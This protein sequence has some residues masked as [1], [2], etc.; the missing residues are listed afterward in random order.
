MDE[1]KE[2]FTSEQEIE[3]TVMT[4]ADTTNTMD[5]NVSEE[6]QEAVASAPISDDN[7]ANS[8]EA[9]NKYI[10]HRAIFV[11][12]IIVIATLAAALIVK[13]FFNTALINTDAFGNKTNTTWHYSQEIPYSDVTATGDEPMIK[14][15]EVDVYYEFTG[16]GK[17]IVKSGTIETVGEYTLRYVD[18]DDISD[19]E[20]GE[21]LLGK[22]V[23]DIDVYDPVIGSFAGIFTYDV[24]GNIFTGKDMKL[25]YLYDDNMSLNFDDKAYEETVLKHEDE[26]T[27][28]KDLVGS[29]EYKNESVTQ[30]FTFREDGTVLVDIVQ[31]Q[32]NYHIKENGIYYCDDSEIDITYFL[33][34]E[35]NLSIKYA[36]RDGKFIYISDILDINGNPTEIEF[37]KV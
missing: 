25:I 30:T 16:D 10:L 8:K 5:S 23:V 33:C 6:S 15:T 13:Y 27:P 26:F 29:W 18:K 21:K 17:L 31:P 37:T 9:K 22:P 32:Y 36:L 3:N 28:N 35:Q 24:S 11:S 2:V 4:D 7:V 20:N 19:I 1:N 34:I 12:I 14:M